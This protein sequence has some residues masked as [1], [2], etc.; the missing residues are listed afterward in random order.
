M[1]F[2]RTIGKRML[3]IAELCKKGT[4]RYNWEFSDSCSTSYFLRCVF[5]NEDEINAIDNCCIGSW[6][7]EYRDWLSPPPHSMS[8]K[9]MRQYLCTAIQKYEISVE[10]I[11]FFEY[12]GLVN[13][14]QLNKCL[15]EEYE[16]A[17]F[18]LGYL[19]ESTYNNLDFVGKFFQKVGDKI[20][21]EC[22]DNSATVESVAVIAALRQ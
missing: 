15:E 5:S 3:V 18:P 6:S 13:E 9:G 17:L 20:L 22:Q 16:D 12:C 4:L 21:K 10:D 2:T 11:I 19:A 7:R 8:I 14:E 1:K